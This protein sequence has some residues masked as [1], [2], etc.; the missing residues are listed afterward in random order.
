ME[1]LMGK[2]KYKVLT[3]RVSDADLAE[4][5]E[6][7]NGKRLVSGRI[8]CPVCGAGKLAWGVANNGHISA[9]CETAGCVSWVE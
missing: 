2:T 7:A 9:T 5:L 8:D 3:L 6:A 4:I 1:I